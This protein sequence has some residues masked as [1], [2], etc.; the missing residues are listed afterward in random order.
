MWLKKVKFY[1]LQRKP[2]KLVENYQNGEFKFC[3]LLRKLSIL[4]LCLILLTWNS[5]RLL[6]PKWYWPSENFCLIIRANDLK[7]C[8]YL[9]S[10][11]NIM[12]EN[13]TDTPAGDGES[14]QKGLTMK[15][16]IH[17]IGCSMSWTRYTKKKSPLKNWVNSGWKSFCHVR[18][19]KLF[20]LSPFVDIFRK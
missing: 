14:Y 5:D 18:W 1:H 20:Y 7:M 4:C 3:E 12:I 11:P 15:F 17:K 8:L 6:K 16:G 19:K 2:T 9:H 10:L 13:H